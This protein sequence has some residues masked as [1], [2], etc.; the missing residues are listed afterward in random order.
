MDGFSNVLV[1]CSHREERP[2]N[3]AGQICYAIRCYWGHTVLT[4]DVDHGNYMYKEQSIAHK[5][6]M[7]DSPTMPRVALTH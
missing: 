2:Y 5:R 6:G 3:L 4:V 1:E 7:S